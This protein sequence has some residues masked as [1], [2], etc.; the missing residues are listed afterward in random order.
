MTHV[1]RPYTQMQTAPPALEVV[2]T[3]GCT[4]ELADGRRLLDGI[5][6]WWTA[7][8]GYNHP[9]IRQRV[10]AQLDRFPHVMFG[11]LTHEPAESLGRRL[12]TLL[13]GDL[14]HCFFTESGSVSVEVGL[15][16]AI[17]AGQNRGHRRKTRWVSFLGGYHGDTFATM[18]LCDP[19]EGMHRRFRDVLPQRRV[20]RLPTTD[21]QQARFS[22]WLERHADEV[23]VVVVEP[24]VQAAGGF[25]FHS[26]EVLRF[27]RR[28]CTACEVSLLFDEIAVGFGRL[29][30]LFACQ[31]ADVVPDIVTLSKALTGGTLP[32]AATVAR[33]PIYEAFLSEDPDDA[34]MHGPTYMANPMGCAAAHGSLDLFEREPRLEQAQRI[35][36]WLRED[37]AEAVSLPG[38]V[39]VRCWG[40]L[41]V[42]ECN[43]ELTHL[44][45]RF[46][47]RGVWVRPLGKVAYLMPP[48]IIDRASC[49]ALARAIVEVLSAD[50]D[51]R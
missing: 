43:R 42:V 46:V 23:A 24:L 32:L 48:L 14:E 49:R 21:E 35:E 10:R 3:E 27:L 38:V 28:V 20:L 47:E 15:K 26:P 34:L 41:G 19:G 29:G 8:H 39:D 12:A 30:H 5:S 44:R 1:W 33:T 7:C 51:S 31:A 4:I 25:R 11:G 45:P 18:S 37:L 9:H 40:A 6:S 13:P 16:M 2:R 22:A 17:Q 36:G 50:V